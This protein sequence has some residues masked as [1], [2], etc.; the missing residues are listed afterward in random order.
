MLLRLLVLVCLFASAAHAEDVRVPA[1]RGALRAAVAGASPGDVLILS[2]GRHDGPVTLSK[3]VTLDG[4]GVATVDAGGEGSVI[5]VT[6]EDITVRGLA[7][8]GSGSDHEGIDSGVQLTKTAR[9][10]VIEGNRILGNLYGVDI[11]GADDSIVRGNLIE[12]RKDRRM[13]DRG[14]GVYVWNAPGARVIGNDIRWGRDGIFVNTSHSNAFVGNRFRDLRFAVHYMYA[15]RSEVRGNLSIG[16]HLGYAVM[17]SKGVR[18]IDNVSVND[19]EHGVMLNY[20][21]G[22]EVRGNLVRDGATKCLFI[23][24]AHK[25]EITGNR[26]ERCGIGV[27]FTAGSERN[28]I[29]GNAFVGNRTQVKYVGTTWVDWSAEGT[30]NYW[31]DF[32]GYDLDADGIADAPY[33]P[34][35]SMD[36]ILWTQPAAK[37]LLGAPAVQLVKWAQSAFPALL[38]GG[39]VDRAPLMQP[40]EISVPDWEMKHDGS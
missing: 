22:S 19:A 33:R 7:I 27:H 12:G 37:L 16:N 1:E 28:A 15:N 6:G 29:S 24:N 13:N 34:N 40:V 9:R 18:I 35:D 32:A 23:Y 36:H 21:N 38:P 3:P 10:A 5:T 30:G 4:R 2:P 14:N 8:V 11:H 20:T 39:V 26:F 31:S 25:N 17:Y